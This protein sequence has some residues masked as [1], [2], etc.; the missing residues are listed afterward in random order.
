MKYAAHAC[1]KIC[2]NL[3]RHSSSTLPTSALDLS[4]YRTLLALSF[5]CSLALTGLSR[6]LMKKSDDDIIELMT[7]QS[8]SPFSLYCSSCVG[9]LLCSRWSLYLRCGQCST[10][11]GCRAERRIG[12]TLAR[13]A[14]QAAE[15]AARRVAP[16]VASGRPASTLF[17]PVQNVQRAFVC[18]PA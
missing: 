6:Q 4:L 5:P 17:R 3:I 13:R 15:P 1:F 9:C 16:R 2:R 10:I 7:P 14:L 12:Y 11:L 8:K 18:N